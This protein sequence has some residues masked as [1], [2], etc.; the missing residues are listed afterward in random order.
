ME[1]R[2][3][4]DAD[5]GPVAKARPNT[6]RRRSTSS[7]EAGTMDSADITI[8][9]ADGP[10][11]AHVGRPTGTPKGGIIVVQEA[12][13][14]TTHIE[15]LTHR[16]ADEGWLAVAPALFHRI[17]APVLAYDD[18]K[19]VMPAMGSL[20]SESIAE[21]IASTLRWLEA[22]GQDAEHTGIV[23][24]CMGGSVTLI[25]A[26]QYA[27]G[28]AVTFYGGGLRDGRFGFPGLIELSPGLRTPWLGL[29]G[30]LDKS[31]PPNDV[32][33]LRTAAATAKTETSIVRYADADHG[34]NCNDR[35]AVYNE[36]A[37]A[38]AWERTLA[39][40]DGHITA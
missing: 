3:P 36:V 21:D 17:G 35:P 30:D 19:P 32:E 40:F 18:L 39:W 13:G 2:Q 25:T 5:R 38:D 9:T 1:R 8:E 28:A 37:A 23:G 7:L 10:M 34:F 15:D 4:R 11:A 12:F 16:L 24:F 14:V 33:A 27:L 6:A 20:T 26:V 22:E 31:I 29:F